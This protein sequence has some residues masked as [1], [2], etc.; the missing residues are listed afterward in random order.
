[1]RHLTIAIPI[2][3]LAV[4]VSGCGQQQDA[5]PSRPAP[6]VQ[7]AK[8]L[9]KEVVEWA[10]FTG[11]LEAV[12]YVEVRSRVS[13]YLAS[14]HFDDGQ[15]VEQGDLLFVIDPRP[16]EASLAKSKATLVEA[17][18]R[19]DQANAQLETA[20]AE[21]DA[22]NSTFDFANRQYE[23]NKKLQST[24]AVSESEVDRTRSE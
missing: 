22:V 12:D 7:V 16:V 1:M 4:I 13:G 5:A 2:A 15:V 6:Q 19:A 8:P 24:R 21:K 11:R 23:R 20:K 18:A 3:M 17:T 10:E 14:I 9:Q